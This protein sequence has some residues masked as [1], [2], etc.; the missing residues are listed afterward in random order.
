MWPVAVDVGILA[1]INLGIQ[2]SLIAIVLVAAYLARKKRDLNKHCTILR[3]AI[4]VQ[5]ASIATIMLPSLL[6][7]MGNGLPI[8]FRSEM[9]THH[10]L[11]LA[12]VALWVYINLAVTGRVKIWGRLA[13]FMRLALSIWLVAFSLGVHLYVQIWIRGA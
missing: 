9:L 4:P 7:Y 10:G 3:I 5:I 6:G 2:A 1:A 11:S 13:I 8:P 12:V